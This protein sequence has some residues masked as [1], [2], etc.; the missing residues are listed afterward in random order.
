MLKSTSASGGRT[1][2]ERHGIHR[3]GV[4]GENV[5]V[6]QESQTLKSNPLTNIVFAIHHLSRNS[7]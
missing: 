6:D 4:V 2:L 5:G 3:E 7:C 1:A